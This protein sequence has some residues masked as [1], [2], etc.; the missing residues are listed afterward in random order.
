MVNGA[1]SPSA[2][3]AVLIRLDYNLALGMLRGG[4]SVKQKVFRIEQMFA[5]RAAQAHAPQR[6][7]DELKTLRAASERRD[8]GTID[9]LK[10]ELAAMRDTAARNSRDLNR[11]IH[12][13][14]ERRMLRAADELRASVDGMDLAT[15]KILSA[16]ELIEDNA[17]ALSASLKSDYERGLAQDIQDHIVRIYEACNFQDLTGQRI[18]NVLAIMTMIED[19]IASIAGHSGAVSGASQPPGKATTAAGNALLNGPKLDDD[20]GHASQTDIDAMFG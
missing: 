5:G 17:R 20:S 6:H 19:R 8:D 3:N 13:G 11:L 7:V 2:R 16:V 4:L 15:Q 10:H 9:A 12:D 14:D 18:N 1:P